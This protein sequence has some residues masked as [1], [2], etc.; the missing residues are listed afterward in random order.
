[1][2][3]SQSCR[4]ISALSGAATTIYRMAVFSSGKLIINT[5]SGGVVSGVLIETVDAA[6]KAVGMALP[7]GGIVKIEAGAAVSQ[8]ANIMSDTSGRAIA[9]TA[10]NNIMGVALEAASAAGEIIAVQLMYLG[11]A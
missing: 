10:T 7:D 6:D 8:D 5:T 9:A 4:T 1:M 11:V 3:F 2:S